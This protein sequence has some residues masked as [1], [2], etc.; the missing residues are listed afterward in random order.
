MLDALLDVLWIGLK[1]G[2][3]LPCHLID[4]IDMGHMLAIF[5]YA[6]DACLGMGSMSGHN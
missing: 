6:N 1:S 5:H 4:Q 3:K 2:G